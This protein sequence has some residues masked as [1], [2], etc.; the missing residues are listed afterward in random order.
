MVFG[1]ITIFL[2]IVFFLMNAIVFAEEKK[3]SQKSID[4]KI[5]KGFNPDVGKLPQKFMGTDIVKLCQ[6]LEKRKP[7][8]KG[9]FETTE[10]YSKR[11]QLA[12]PED[13]YAFIAEEQV[14]I[15]YD[16]DKNLLE[17]SSSNKYLKGM[18]RKYVE[19]KRI[20][21]TGSHRARNAFG[22]TTEVTTFRDFEYGIALHSD[23]KEK[24]VSASLYE[25]GDRFEEFKEF[26]IN[27]TMSPEEAKRN[28]E[29][30]RVLV[31]SQIQR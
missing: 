17:I 1:K 23:F 10:E 22:A 12:I 11:A 20:Q 21:K 24:G 4:T 31:L 6:L 15:R 18:P 26:N 29:E 25:Y 13:I 16:A 9:E 28:K 30:I 19:I 27:I 14:S 5:L 2:L 3:K 8:E 7:K